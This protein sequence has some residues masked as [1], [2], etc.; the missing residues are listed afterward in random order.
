MGIFVFMQNGT[1][2]K[3]LTVYAFLYG[4]LFS[5][6]NSP[7]FFLFFFSYLNKASRNQK[8]TNKNTLGNYVGVPYSILNF[9]KG[10]FLIRNGKKNCILMLQSGN[11]IF[12]FT[13]WNLYST[14]S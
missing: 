4:S 12:D 6:R 10:M 8:K 2:T 7:A 14:F 5:Y 3:C 9:I 11:T 13:S 1:N